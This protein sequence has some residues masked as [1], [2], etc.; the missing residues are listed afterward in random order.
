MNK[1]LI[2]WQR[3]NMRQERRGAI[4]NELL[5]WIFASLVAGVLAYTLVGVVDRI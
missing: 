1:Q 5:T 3:E 2:E 4:K